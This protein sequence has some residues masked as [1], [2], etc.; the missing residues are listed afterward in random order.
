V[1]ESGPLVSLATIC[2]HLRAH[3]YEV[4]AEHLL[5][6]GVPVQFIPAY[7]ALVKEALEQANPKPSARPRRACCGW[8]TCSPS[9]FKPTGPRT[10]SAPRD[11][12]DL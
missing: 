4:A 1:P 9:C 5:I 2:D 3:G 6:A 12:F 10:A 11:E 8:S 7:N